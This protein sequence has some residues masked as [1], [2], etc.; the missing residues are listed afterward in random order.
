MGAYLIRAG[1]PV[2]FV[3]VAADH[4]QAINADGLK[5]EGPIDNFRVRAEAMLPKD[6]SG[7]YRQIVLAV[8]AHHTVA[9]TK[10]LAP[11]LAADGYVLSAQNGLNE[12]EIAKILGAERTIGAFVNFGA[13]YMR[14]GVVMYG[15]RG[16]VV[17]GELDGSRTP[18]LEALYRCLQLFEPD[19]VITDDI[20]GYLW[21]KLGYGALLFATALTE[22]SIADVLASMP[23]QALLRALAEEVMRVA[24]AKGVAPKGF[25]GFD[26]KAFMAGA[27]G[28]LAAASMQ[29][30]VEFNRRSAKSH[31]GIYRDLA[32]RKRKTEIDA[33]IGPIAGIGREQGVATP[34]TDRLIQL[35]R[36]L[37]DG[38]RHMAWENL[39]ALGAAM[40]VEA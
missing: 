22:A 12:I 7:S 16:A 33:Q 2:R 29:A 11:S 26:P 28:A 37:E 27:N 38:K 34:I 17:L 5:I 10:A 15:G 21:G 14:P 18:R 35:I 4:V 40:Q 25:N 6:V 8:K 3:D 1:V 24:A 31:S 20:W 36:E 32:V 9:A 23:H 39:D 13:D 19:A 30:M